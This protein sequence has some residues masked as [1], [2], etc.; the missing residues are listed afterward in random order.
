[1]NQDPVLSGISHARRIVA[2]GIFFGLFLSRE[3]YTKPPFMLG[4][5]PPTPQEEKYLISLP[6]FFSPW[7]DRGFS[8]PNQTDALL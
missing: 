3:A 5:Q 4:V 7:G 6:P 1:M 8:F 2:I